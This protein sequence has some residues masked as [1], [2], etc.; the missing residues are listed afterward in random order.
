MKK[1]KIIYIKINLDYKILKDELESN[2]QIKS[3]TEKN[4]KN[5]VNI[6]SIINLLHK[7]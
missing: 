2:Q 3:I 1:R 6:D 4:L 5:I 7:I